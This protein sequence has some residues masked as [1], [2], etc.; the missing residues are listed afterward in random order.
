MKK[1]V[2]I[3]VQ[4]ILQ[5]AD[6]GLRVDSPAFRLLSSQEKKEDFKQ[7]RAQF[8][9]IMAMIRS[10]SRPRDEHNRIPD[11]TPATQTR[12]AQSEASA[13]LNPKLNAD[14]NKNHPKNSLDS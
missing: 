14:S 11:P 4:N 1:I 3:Q 8:T 2:A 12:T 5:S 10:A 6:Y 7:Y 13:P 9:M